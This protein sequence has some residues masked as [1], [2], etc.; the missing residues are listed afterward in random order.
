MKGC[1]L[2]IVDEPYTTKTCGKCGHLNQHIGSKD[3]FTCNAKECK[4]ERDNQKMLDNCGMLLAQHNRDCIYV[5]GRDESA[6]RNITLLQLSYFLSEENR[7][8]LLLLLQGQA[9]NPEI[10]PEPDP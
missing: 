4:Y 6:A 10:D 5:S 7:D 9:S 2:V 1:E 8:L 3:V